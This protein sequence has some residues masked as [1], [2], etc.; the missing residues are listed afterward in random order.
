[1]KIVKKKKQKKTDIKASLVHGRLLSVIP[2]RH[3]SENSLLPVIASE[4]LK[5]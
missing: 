2:L 5:F 4:C 3:E 1:M